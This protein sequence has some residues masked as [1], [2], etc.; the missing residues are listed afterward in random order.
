MGNKFERGRIR[1]VAC[2]RIVT[3]EWRRSGEVN[4]FDCIERLTDLILDMGEGI[5][6]MPSRPRTLSERLADEALIQKGV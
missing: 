1:G 3:M 4:E 5:D 6:K 2:T